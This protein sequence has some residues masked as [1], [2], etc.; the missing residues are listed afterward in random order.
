MKSI[1]RQDL[2]V[3][4]V[5]TVTAPDLR[6]ILNVSS[7][8]GRPEVWFE[9]DTALPPRTL[10]LWIVGTGNPIPAEVTNGRES[11]YVGLFITSGGAFVWHL[12]SVRAS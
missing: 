6:R 5:Q 1:Y 9:V 7:E 4:E 8:R 11:T 2:K 12:Y 10:T 3:T